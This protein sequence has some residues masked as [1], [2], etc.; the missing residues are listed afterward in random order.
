M[1]IYKKSNYDRVW[2]DIIEY[3][4]R[5]SKN[6]DLLSYFYY[7]KTLNKDKQY[8]AKALLKIYQYQPE[9]EVRKYLQKYTA[10][11][12]TKKSFKIKKKNNLQNFIYR[13]LTN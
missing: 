6:F 10:A 8:L 1:T 12:L 3:Y 11:N 2:I 7:V 5:D 13:K 9:E 4:L